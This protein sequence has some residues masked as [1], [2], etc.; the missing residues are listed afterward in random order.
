MSTTIKHTTGTKSVQAD[1]TRPN[2]RKRV[3]WLCLIWLASIAALG[4]VSLL[5]RFC[6]RLAG[7]HT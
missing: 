6:M 7:L 2:W 3:G 5:L 4:V 1:T